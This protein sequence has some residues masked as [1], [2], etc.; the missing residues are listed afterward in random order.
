MIASFVMSLPPLSIMHSCSRDRYQV[1]ACVTDEEASLL[2]PAFIA[3]DNGKQ[4]EDFVAMSTPEAT[5]KST[6]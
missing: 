3:D 1:D 6:S 2:S 4:V 5:L